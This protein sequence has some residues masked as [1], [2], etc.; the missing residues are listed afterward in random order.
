MLVTHLPQVAAAGHAHIQVSK[1]VR[2]G[3]TYAQAATLD[4]EER[5]AEIARMLSGGVAEATALE[6][7][8]E[9]LRDSHKSV[10]SSQAAPKRPRR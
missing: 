2:S 8:R 7:A 4:E 9:L 3:K 5:I 6:H 1:S 10:V